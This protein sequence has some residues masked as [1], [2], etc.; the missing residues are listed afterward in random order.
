[1]HIVPRLY[2]SPPL[3]ERATIDESRST[4]MVLST[5][6]ARM[7]ACTLRGCFR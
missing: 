1:M 4:E 3:L 7:I 5:D 6:P 2:S